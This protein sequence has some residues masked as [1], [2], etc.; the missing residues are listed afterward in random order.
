MLGMIAGETVLAEM[1]SVRPDLV[2][3]HNQPAATRSGDVEFHLGDLTY[4]LKSLM[5][6]DV[7]IERTEEALESALM[8]LRFWGRFYFRSPLAGQAAMELAN[9]LQVA[10]CVARGATLRRESRGVH[11]RGDVAEPCEARE[12]QH[13]VLEPAQEDG[14]LVLRA[15][16][17]PLHSAV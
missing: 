15:R 16:T 14:Q 1:T 10:Y 5:W 12:A 4:S 9:M 8:R 3:I 13:V 2:G 6:R 11:Y 17:E 7:G